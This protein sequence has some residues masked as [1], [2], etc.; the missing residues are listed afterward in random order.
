MYFLK[1]IIVQTPYSFVAF[2]DKNL[3]LIASKKNTEILLT[4]R[5]KRTGQVYTARTTYIH[6]YYLILSKTNAIIYYI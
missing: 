1:R 6:R 2:V 5:L 4:I 3:T